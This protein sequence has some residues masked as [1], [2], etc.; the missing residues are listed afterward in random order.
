MLRPTK[1]NALYDLCRRNFV[2]DRGKG[3]FQMHGDAGKR[4][5]EVQRESMKPKEVGMLQLCSQLW[6]GYTVPISSAIAQITNDGVSL[7]GQ[8]HTNLMRSARYKKNVQQCRKFK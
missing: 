5:R 8:V 2:P 7:R 3:C 4:V 6:I 1:C